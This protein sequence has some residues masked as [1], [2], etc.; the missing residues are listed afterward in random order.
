MTDN[1]E[2]IERVFQSR[3]NYAE[4]LVDRQIYFNSFYKLVRKYRYEVASNYLTGADVIYV[5]VRPRDHNK[6]LKDPNNSID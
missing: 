1:L 4:F 2:T 6:L 5:R 3:V